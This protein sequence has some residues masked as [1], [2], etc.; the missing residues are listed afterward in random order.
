MALFPQIDGIHIQK[1]G[2]TRQ[3]ADSSTYLRHVLLVMQA[4]AQQ[5]LHDVVVLQPLPQLL[6]EQNTGRMCAVT[7]NQQ[8]P[9]FGC[10]QFNACTAPSMDGG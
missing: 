3:S 7:P 1:A 2:S 10:S 9:C 6:Q 8:E 4:S 5:S